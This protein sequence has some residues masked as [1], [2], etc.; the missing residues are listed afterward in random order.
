[1]G[2]PEREDQQIERQ[3]RAQQEAEDSDND[4]WSDARESHDD[5]DDEQEAEP[6][7][8]KTEEE[9]KKVQET[10][11][12]SEPAVEESPVDACGDV[13]AAVADEEEVKP[14]NAQ[15][16]PAEKAEENENEDV[17]E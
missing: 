14:T 13:T 12:G 9:S 4:R 7:P 5:A 15:I 11:K 3:E 2:L 1:M 6:L 10:K 17:D 8:K 16:Q